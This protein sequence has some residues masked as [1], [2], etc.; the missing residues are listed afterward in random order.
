MSRKLIPRNWKT[1]LKVAAIWQPVTDLWTRTTAWP[2]VGRLT[3]WIVN[4]E[5]YD[6][7]LIPVNRELETGSTVVPRQAVE[8]IVRHSCHRVIVPLC[9]CRVGCR[10]QNHPME[11]GC[12]FMGEATRQIDPSIGRPVSVEEAL[13]HV[14]RAVKAGLVIQIGR[15]DPDPFM[16]GIPMKDWG[17]FLTL[18]F[19]CPCCCI[20]MRN[21]HNWDPDIRNRIHR[22]E[23]LR[24][25]VTD[26]CDG[27]GKCAK[28]CFTGAIRLSDKRAII[29]EECKGCGICASVC[30][31]KAIKVEVADG[32]LMMN[33]F[34][35]RVESYA[36]VTGS[37]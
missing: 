7:T 26:A 21:I 15:V 5:H 33:E 2:V 3:G 28:A 34:L 22:L 9:M 20:A 12:I 1:F 25:E 8:E 6:V 29:G 35:R 24:I 19:C 14:E 23:G 30:P 36:D 31:K 17:R 10:C 37:T 13:A 4:R 27:C 18:C 16:L 11:I 32:T